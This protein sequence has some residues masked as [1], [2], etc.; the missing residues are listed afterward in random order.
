[1]NKKGGKK[2]LE[3]EMEEEGL[4]GQGASAVAPGGATVHPRW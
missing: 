3:K 4:G 2:R 1:M